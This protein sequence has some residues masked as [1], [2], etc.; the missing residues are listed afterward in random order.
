MPHES[1]LE[2]SDSAGAKRI[3][4]VRWHLWFDALR[5]AVGLVER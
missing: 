3:S 5:P 2:H 1:E 4:L